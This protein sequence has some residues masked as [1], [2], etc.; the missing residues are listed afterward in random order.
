MAGNRNSEMGD[1]PSSNV[2]HQQKRVY[3]V[4]RGGN[5]FFCGGRM[6]FGPDVASLFLTTFLIAA[7]AITFCVKIYLQIKNTSDLTSE[8]WFPV[9]V[10]GAVLTVLDLMFLL[11]TSGRD[12]GIVPR[13]LRPPEFDDTFDIPTPSMEWINGTTPH[14]KLPRTKDVVVNGQVVKVKFCDT[15]LLYRPPR[16]SHCSICNNCVERFDHHC[17]WVGQCIGTRNYRY[18]FM[19]ILTSTTLCLYV[20]VFTCVSISERNVWK[21][22]SRDY[23]SDFLII[24]CFIAVWFVG[25]LTAFHFY[26]IC[27]NQT[28]YENFRY[29]YDKKGNPFNRGS[30]RNINETL[31]SSAPP[32][33]NDFRA[34]V[35]EDEHM[36]VRSLTPNIADGILT[37]KEK[38]DLE[39]GSMRAEDDE[40]QLSYD[41][42]YSVEDDA[43]GSSR[44][45]IATVLNF[46]SISEEG[47]EEYVQSSHAGGRVG[48]S[49]QRHITSDGTYT[50]KETNGRNHSQ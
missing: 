3:E 33:K 45:S 5:K 6:I 1:S 9:V 49:T 21:T 41:P 42:F 23:L 31:C 35:V 32:S 50:N 27:T 19:F 28:T 40:G 8:F 26:L 37:P 39:M 4:W 44:T 36:M 2:G 30:C 11:M 18:F 48:E 22:I 14:L 17:P 46:Q 15:C 20:F 34:F 16:T 38:I 12:P 24:Y 29:Q 10:V 25:G 43:K 13:N 7:P 47:M